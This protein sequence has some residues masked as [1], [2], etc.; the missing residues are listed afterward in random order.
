MNPND[1]DDWRLYEK[2]CKGLE[3][4]DQFDGV[5]DNAAR[6]L[7]LIG[8]LMEKCKVIDALNIRFE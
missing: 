5:S 2:G 7:K 6:F 8:N 1:K 3:K 4:E